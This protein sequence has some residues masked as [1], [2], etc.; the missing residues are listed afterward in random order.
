MAELTDLESKLGEV[1]GLALMAAEAGQ[2]VQ[3]R[4]RT[5]SGDELVGTLERMRGKRGRRRSVA[6]R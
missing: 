2:R 5:R 3:A 6:A 4:R 1:V